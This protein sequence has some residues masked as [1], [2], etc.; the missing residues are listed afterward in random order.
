MKENLTQIIAVLDK[1]GSMHHL[2]NDTIGGFN[3]FIEEQSKQPGDLVITTVL[4]N[5]DYQVLHDQKNLRDLSNLTDKDYK[6]EGNTALLDAMGKAMIDVG[7]KLADM[8]EEDRP[9][10]VIMFVITDGMEN[11]SREYTGKQIKEMVEEQQNKYSWEF[12]FIG[13]N[14]DAFAVGNDLGIMRSLNYKSN[15]KGTANLYCMLNSTV[16]SYH[17]RS[18]IADNEELEAE[19]NEGA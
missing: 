13:A 11:A 4:F 14:I 12:M 1:S 16:S 10:K 3:S 6:A 18:V 15:E 5:S 17:N 2:T 19:L 8:N 9:S 7:R